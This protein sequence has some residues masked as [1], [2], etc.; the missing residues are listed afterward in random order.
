GFC[1]TCKLRATAGTVDHRDT[2]L[3]DTERAD[4]YLLTCVSRATTP[5]TLNI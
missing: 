3:T 4:G 1:G 5:L 2:I